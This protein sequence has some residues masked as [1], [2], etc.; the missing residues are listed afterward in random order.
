VTHTEELPVP[1]RSDTGNLEDDAEMNFG[2]EELDVNGLYHDIEYVPPDSENPLLINHAE[3]NGGM[4]KDGIFQKRTQ[5][6]SFFVTVKITAKF[7]F[8]EW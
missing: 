3:L 2:D 5:N 7:L 6:A 8:H 1:E 4:M